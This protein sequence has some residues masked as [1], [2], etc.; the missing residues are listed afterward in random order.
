M[1]SWK[2]LRSI[3]GVLCNCRCQAAIFL[4]KRMSHSE[5]DCARDAPVYQANKIAIDMAHLAISL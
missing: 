1:V 4:E 5:V 3:F 2:N